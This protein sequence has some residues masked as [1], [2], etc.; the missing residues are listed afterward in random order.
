MLLV[1]CRKDQE[2]IT[3]NVTGKIYCYDQY[4][5]LMPDQ[6]GIAVK[7]YRDTAL[8]NSTLTDSRGQYLFEH[9]SY[10]KYSISCEKDFFILPSWPHII[11]N[12]GGYSPTLADLNL[13]E[14]P[15]YDL[16]LDSVGYLAEYYTYVIYTKFNGDTLLPQYGS[17]GLPLKVFAGNTPEISS[18]NYIS[19]GD[20]YL[21][22]ISG[23]EKVAVYAI[24]WSMDQFFNHLKDGTIYL[25]MYPIA[26]GQGFVPSS[27]NPRALGSPSNVISFK[28]DELAGRP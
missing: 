11:Y 15:T 5:F 10:G 14:I 17:Y 27:Y 26:F 2:I 21:E 6:P 7:L 4:G 28:W 20:A 25:R 1:D 23:T 24:L 12:A 3:G 19:T 9:M 18:E 8:L 22:D 13:H 16:F